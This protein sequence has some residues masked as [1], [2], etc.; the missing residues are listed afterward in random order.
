MTRLP[1]KGPHFFHIGW[2]EAHHGHLRNELLGVE[3]ITS[4]ASS[5]IKSEHVSHH[6]R[7]PLRYPE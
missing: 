2:F 3:S 7:Y 5:A 1:S 4:A 6:F